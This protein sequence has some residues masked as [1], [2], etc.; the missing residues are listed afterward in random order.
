MR[1]MVQFVRKEPTVESGHSTTKLTYA[2]YLRLP[3]DGLRH[4][5]IDGEHYVTP[6]P[7]V[8]HQEISGR[9]FYQI[10]QYLERQPIGKLFYAPLDALLSEFDI[11]VPDLV[12]ISNERSSFLTAKNLQGPPDLVI[13][14]LSPST[15]HRDLGIKRDLYGRVGIQ[16]YWLVD[17]MQEV[18]DVC[19]SESGLTF[20]APVKYAK[21]AILKS[22]LFPGLEL[23][24]GRVFA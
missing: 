4:E 22:P 9:L 5:I 21:N 13:E 10:Q 17:Q 23:S 1:T 16:E 6:A 20:A 12:Y 3:D 7:T 14:I 11:V 15:K 8:R 24:L 19:R 18:V 2:D